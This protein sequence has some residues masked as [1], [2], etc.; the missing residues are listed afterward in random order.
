MLFANGNGRGDSD[1]EHVS[2][3][4]GTELRLPLCFEEKRWLAGASSVRKRG[5]L[6]QEKDES[7]LDHAADVASVIARKARGM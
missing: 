4:D 3:L 6:L 5:M 1:P 7:V 2:R